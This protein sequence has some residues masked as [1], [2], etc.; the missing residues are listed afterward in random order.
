MQDQLFEHQDALETENLIQYAGAISLDRPRFV[1][2][3]SGHVYVHRVQDDLQ[4]AARSGV[5]GTPTFFINGARYEGLARPD[6]LYRAM[7]RELGEGSAD[8]IAQV[9]ANSFAGWTRVRI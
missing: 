6:A 1:A 9:F 3:L 5:H 2:D 8:E 7:L 4:S